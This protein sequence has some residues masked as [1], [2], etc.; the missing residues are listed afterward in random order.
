[1]SSE[2]GPSQTL[3]INNINEKVKKDVLKKT[4]YML[5]RQYGKILEIIACK[6]LQRRGQAFIVFEDIVASTNA[7]KSKQGFNFYDKP[8]VCANEWFLIDV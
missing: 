7:M 1:M 5:F 4:L 3:Y 6:G 2:N 8:L